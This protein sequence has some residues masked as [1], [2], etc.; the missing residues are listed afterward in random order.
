MEM[1]AGWVSANVLDTGGEGARDTAGYRRLA[2]AVDI[3][4]PDW[5]ADAA[6][7][8]HPEVNWFPERGEDVRPA[9]R[10]CGGCL[11]RDECRTWALSQDTWLVGIWA[12]TSQRD[13][14][15]AHNNSTQAA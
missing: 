3:A 8:E 13:R 15:R 14:R 9:R 5:H 6:C 11:V 12:G 4:T 2:A 7:R 10:I 1:A